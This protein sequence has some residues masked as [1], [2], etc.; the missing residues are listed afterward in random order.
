MVS[1]QHTWNASQKPNK[2]KLVEAKEYLKHGVLF[3]QPFKEIPSG[4]LLTVA[5]R[6]TSGV[7]TKGLQGFCGSTGFC[8]RKVGR[9]SSLSL[10][11]TL[12][13][14]RPATPSSLTSSQR[15]VRIP[16]PPCMS[17]LNGARAATMPNA[18]GPFLGVSYPCYVQH[19]LG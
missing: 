4:T 12:R 16:L 6:L 13:I 17:S 8:G 14:L 19:C 18:A 9:R 2:K 15:S 7:K 11:T 10:D 5:W 1:C 3:Q